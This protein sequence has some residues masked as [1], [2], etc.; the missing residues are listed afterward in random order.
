MIIVKVGG[1]K[2]IRW[3]YICCNIASLLEHG[4]KLVVVHGASEI[5]DELAKKMGFQTQTVTS[6]SGISSVYTD[7]KALEIF[8]MSYAG[9][10]NSTIVSK[11]QAS[12]INAIGLSGI[13][14]RLWEAKAKPNLMVQ[15]EGKT[16]L[17][18]DNMTGR[19]EK[20]N[21]S[22]IRLL[23]KNNYLPVISAPAISFDSQIVNTDNDWATAVMAGALGAKS[24]VYL[25]EAQG[26]MKDLH[27]SSSVISTIDKN[28]LDSFMKFAQGRMKKKVMGAQKALKLGV[29]KIY[30][31]DGRIKNPIQSALEGKGTI[32]Y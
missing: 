14:G 27:D 17:I 4:E 16:R 6:P 15:E 8:L 22:L 10:A 13:D 19:V 32:I 26:L 31:G 28:K 29:E 21:T 1:G 24:V 5:R 25:F 11:M 30:F 20:V 9:F 23:L 3:D 7:K 2:T 18:R 12:G